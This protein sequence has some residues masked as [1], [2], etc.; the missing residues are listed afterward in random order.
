MKAP[1]LTSLQKVDTEYREL[2]AAITESYRGDWDDS[3]HRSYNRYVKNVE[4]NS[5][6]IHAVNRQ[7]RQIIK[8]VASLNV[9]RLSKRADELQREAE[10]L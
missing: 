8:A 5:N 7:S 2:S 10:I 9:E 6:R 3:V 4:Q 1:D